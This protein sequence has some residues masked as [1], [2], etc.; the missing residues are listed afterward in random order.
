MKRDVMA[1]EPV[2]ADHLAVLD[3]GVAGLFAVLIDDQ[4]VVADGVKAI[5]V[6]PRDLSQEIGSG[7]E[8]IIEN[9]IAQALGREQIGC[10]RSQPELQLLLLSNCHSIAFTAWP[11]IA[12]V[13]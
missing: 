12:T 3:I 7:A 4:Q 9:P 5:T 10:V 6:E 2:G 1:Q 11:A 8:F 13:T